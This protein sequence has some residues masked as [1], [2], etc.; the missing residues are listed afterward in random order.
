MKK[1]NFLLKSNDPIN[2]ELGA[3]SKKGNNDWITS[4]IC[5][6]ADLKIDLLQSF[7]FPDNTI[8][9]IYSSHV[10][11]HFSIRQIEHILSECYRVLKPDGEINVCVPNAEIYINAYNNPKAFDFEFYCRY[12]PGFR[13]YSKIDYINYIAYMNGNHLYMFDNDNIIKILIKNKF[14]N[15]KLRKFDSKIDPR[16]R[17]YE[18][19]Y[20]LGYK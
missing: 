3:G 10:L 13:F 15:V 20:A 16:E 17:D 14:R 8:D 19:I 2:L 18:S 4:D 11:E 5:K 9:R 6:G 12:K 1:I 7:P